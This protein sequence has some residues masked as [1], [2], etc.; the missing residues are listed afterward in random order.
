MKDKDIEAFM[1][2][3]AGNETDLDST[4]L[5]S[6]DERDLAKLYEQL[7]DPDSSDPIE[8]RKYTLFQNRLA[9]YKAGF[10]DAEAELTR[11]K[12]D[13]QIRFPRTY[14]ASISLFAAAACILISTFLILD[15]KSGV[16]PSGTVL[17][18]EVA[19]LKNML[20][21][22]LL[23][24]EAPAQRMNGISQAVLLESPSDE[25]TK[26]L[27]WILN[28]DPNVNVRLATIGGLEN[29]NQDIYGKLLDSLPDQTSVLVQ[30]EIVH[31]VLNFG[32]DADRSRLIEVI[33]ESDLAPERT[34]RFKNVINTGI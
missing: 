15:W 28:N 4:T 12:T 7:K 9:A 30:L 19:D 27:F 20:V 31:T 3:L 6:D 29:L 21:L 18:Q 23:S 32:E 22:S 1:D 8:N 17:K 33:T 10:G 5:F 16:D 2:K 34:T 24:H 25:I 26:L 11:K 13:Q 14:A